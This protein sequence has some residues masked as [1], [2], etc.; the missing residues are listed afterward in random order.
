MRRVLI[1]LPFALFAAVLALVASGLI[2]PADRTVH[3]AM[4]D[5][6]LP[7]IDLPP[8]LASKDGIKGGFGGK[9]RLINVFASWCLPCIAE[10]RQLMRLKA[11]GVQIDGVATA[12]TT[13]AMQA[14]LAQ[15]GDPYARI[16]DDRNRKVQ[17]SLGSAGV[18]ETFVVDARGR[19]VK[20]HIGDVREDDVPEILAALEAAK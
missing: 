3:S 15:N 6:P 16:G 9:P 12:D 11:M 5:K 2:K 10:A 18:P 19:I 20:Q 13:E 7:A 8:L 4:I 17:F 14:F 1:W